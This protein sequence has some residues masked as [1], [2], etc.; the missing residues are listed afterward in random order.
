MN[1]YAEI[2][3][4]I[5]SSFERKLVQEIVQPYGATKR[6]PDSVL[7]TFQDKCKNLESSTIIGML[8]HILQN[9]DAPWVSQLRALYAIESLI[10]IE[11]YFKIMN[12]NKE[13]F[14]NM[15]FENVRSQSASGA[16]SMFRIKASIKERLEN[17]FTVPQSKPMEVDLSKLEALKEKNSLK[18]FEKMDLIKRKQKESGGEVDLLNNAA[19]SK[20][21][22]DLMD[23]VDLGN[24]PRDAKTA[25][26]ALKSQDL[27]D[28]DLIPDK[29]EMREGKLKGPNVESSACK[30]AEDNLDLVGGFNLIKIDPITIKNS[31]ELIDLI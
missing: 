4:E 19:E 18:F 22:D 6:P 14:A 10:K 2:N 20:L 9:D 11:D 28:L 3:S 30:Q 21:A 15:S 8:F 7:G 31:E 13:Q 25:N 12:Y 1:S 27:L 26:L 24:K 5:I 29:S 17:A 16:E 23:L